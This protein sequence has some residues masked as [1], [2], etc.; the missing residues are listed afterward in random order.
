[1]RD[2]FHAGAVIVLVSL[3]LVPGGYAQEQTNAP[4]PTKDTIHRQVQ[5]LQQQVKALQAVRRVPAV[6]AIVVISLFRD[7]SDLGL[8]FAHEYL[9][10]SVSGYGQKNRGS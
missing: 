2:C 8:D 3:L 7:C 10:D 6:L 9:C 4:P 1:M 5:E